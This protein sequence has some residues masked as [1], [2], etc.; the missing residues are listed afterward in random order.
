M[1]PGTYNLPS[2]TEGDTWRGVPALRV[3]VNGAPPSQ[4][5]ALVRMQI[6]RR[7]EDAAALVSL[8]SGAGG[9]IVIGDAADWDVSIPP[10][11]LD[12]PAGRYVHDIEFTDAAG[13]V[14]TYLAGGIAVNKQVTR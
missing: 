8:H 11:V 6:R 13:T 14:S 3:R 9:G 2:V 5:L 1:K 4:P 7:A 12:L 10:R